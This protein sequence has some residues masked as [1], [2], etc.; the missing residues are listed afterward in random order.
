MEGFIFGTK[1]L[2]NISPPSAITLGLWFQR[3]NSEEIQIYNPQVSHQD[4]FFLLQYLNLYGAHDKTPFSN[5]PLRGESQN[6]ISPQ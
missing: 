1:Y 6:V 2:L 4:L 5:H 3:M